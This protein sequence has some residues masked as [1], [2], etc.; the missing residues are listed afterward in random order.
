MNSFCYFARSN[1][2]LSLAPVDAGGILPNV[3][4]L[5]TPV[6]YRRFLDVNETTPLH[7]SK[8]FSRPNSNRRCLKLVVLLSVVIT[9][10]FSLFLGIKLFLPGKIWNG[11]SIFSSAAITSPHS[12]GGV[13]RRSLSGCRLRNG[14]SSAISTF[15]PVVHH[16]RRDG[17]GPTDALSS[18]R[19]RES[20]PVNTF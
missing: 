14:L 18:Y 16:F 2:R 9:T 12:R 5:M 11:Y 10:S 1:H 19:E 4:L 13:G 20:L 15:I 6:V 3:V 7:A 17:L 8:V